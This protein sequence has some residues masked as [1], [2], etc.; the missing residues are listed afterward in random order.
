MPEP[1]HSTRLVSTLKFQGNNLHR[2]LEIKDLRNAEKQLQ[3]RPS[4]SYSTFS[5]FVVMIR[6]SFE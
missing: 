5:L 6:I 1:G 4:K 2:Q 3:E